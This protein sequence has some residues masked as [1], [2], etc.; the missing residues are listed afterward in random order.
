V[1]LVRVCRTRSRLQNL[2][3]GWVENSRLTRELVERLLGSAKASPTHGS[4]GMNDLSVE[5]TLRRRWAA[6][7]SS[8]E[9]AD[10][11]AKSHASRD[12]DS[13]ASWALR[14]LACD[15]LFARSLL[16]LSTIWAAAGALDV[17]A[18][19]IRRAAA[20]EPSLWTAW[21]NMSSAL[22][23]LDSEAKALP[24]Q[25]RAHI[26][27]APEEH[28]YQLIFLELLFG[29]A[30][31]A[32]RHLAE[33]L[34]TFPNPDSAIGMV[35]TAMQRGRAI[36]A[37]IL[38]ETLIAR[39]PRS[40]NV[41]MMLQRVRLR[42]TRSQHDIRAMQTRWGVDAK[43]GYYPVDTERR[44]VAPGYLLIRG[45]NCGFWGEVTHVA[46]NV[47]LAEIMG[48]IPLVYWGR[49]VR[50]RRQDEGNAWDL[51][52]E[53]LSDVALS[54]LRVEQRDI[55]PGHWTAAS[56]CKSEHL[57]H[58]QMLSG[59]PQGINAIAAVNR[60]EAILVSDGFV[61]MRDVLA[62]AAPGHRW[63]QADPVA[64]YQEIFSRFFRP[65]AH[66]AQSIEQIAVS[67]LG[68][69]PVIA[70]HVRAQ[71]RGKSG[72]SIE[73]KNVESSAYFAQIDRWLAQN[74]A[75]KLFLLTDIDDAIV[76]FRQRYGERVLVLDRVRIS[77]PNFG[78][79]GADLPRASDIGFG[80]ELDGYQLGLEVLTDAYLAA[81]CDRFVGDG[82]SA[83]S[84][85]ILNLKMWR[86]EDVALI[87]QNVFLERSAASREYT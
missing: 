62:W 53:P 76:A 71:S 38:G 29:D 78:R 39:F 68:G 83:V 51:F 63:Q 10:G 40:A 86:S 14:A 73:K 32:S 8:P 16:T 58:L 28:R 34:D 22:V 1:G 81:A 61:E 47:A 35:Y 5:L 55:H 80:A 43:D 18:M 59:N 85:S 56:L 49:E 24:Y 37:A 75:Y 72:E 31:V 87:R 3:S 70:V 20:L 46:I 77:T 11:L 45:F 57:Q 23:H 19:T 66:I 6:D 60:P 13:A 4:A 17:A 42:L 79:T 54:E 27:G 67:L 36:S 9:T 84:C 52:F 50:Y 41:A 30:E 74:P 7:P 2:A 33:A 25:R 82:A 15:P 64:V 69:A 65:R 48:R 21:H 12:I 26:S 44:R